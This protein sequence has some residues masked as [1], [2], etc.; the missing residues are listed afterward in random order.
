MLSANKTLVIE[1][2]AGQTGYFV[3]EIYNDGYDA[4]QIGR[5]YKDDGIWGFYPTLNEKK[6]TS[7]IMEDLVIAI[8]S[9]NQKG[10]L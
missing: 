8:K 10:T 4:I 5:L 7:E 6:F 9:L 1:R 2:F 3:Y